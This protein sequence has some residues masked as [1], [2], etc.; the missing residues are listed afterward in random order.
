MAPLPALT[1]K[2]HT[3]ADVPEESLAFALFH[4]ELQRETAAPL[5]SFADEDLGKWEKKAIKAVKARKSANVPFE[6][7]SIPADL[8]YELAEVLNH[9]IDSAHVKATF[10]AL[11]SQF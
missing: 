7:D 2:R 9:C 1:K 3:L 4:R 6:S 10:A 8:Q 11:K 5:E